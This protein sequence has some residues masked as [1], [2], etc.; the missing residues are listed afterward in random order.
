MDYI[1]KDWLK[2]IDKL[3]SSLEKDVEEVRAQK[4]EVQR[5]KAEILNDISAG[6]YIRDDRKIVIS[7][8][9]IIIG[10]VDMS[11][12]LWGDGTYSKVTIRA[13]EVETNGVGRAGNTAGGSITN[14]ASNIRNIAVDPGMDGLENVV[15]PSSQIVNQARSIIIQSNDDDGYFSQDLSSA[16]GTGVLIHADSGITVDATMSTVRHSESLKE[17]EKSLKDEQKNLKS[18]VSD[19]KSSVSALIS[20]IEKALDSTEGKNGS[21][22]DVFANLDDLADIQASYE[23]LTMALYNAMTT[24]LHGLSALAET[25]RALSAL[26]ETKKEIDSAKGDFKKNSTGSALTLNSET[27]TV[28][29][30]DGDGNVRESSAAGFYVNAKRVNLASMQADGTVLKDSEFVAASENITLSTASPKP[31]DGGPEFLAAGTMRLMSKDVSISAMDYEVKDKK[32]KEKA[33]AKDGSVL[34]RAE[35]VSVVA[36]TPDGKCDGSVNINAK[37]IG[38]KSMDLDKDSLE[39]KDLA[40]GSTMVLVSEKMYAG[41]LEKDKNKSKQFQIASDKIGVVAKTTAE[42]QQD[43]A[44]VQLDGGNLSAGG[45]KTNIFG[46]TTVNGKAEFKADVKAPKLTADNLEA[47]KSFKSTNISDG[48]A[49][50]GAPSSASLSQKIK[51]EAAPKSK[52]LKKK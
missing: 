11:G 23:S 49:V 24:Y 35:N 19:S 6:K 28:N 10:N 39:E 26:A 2:A 20:E 46:A 5:M 18:L 40:A 1:F 8:P 43:K 16:S 3:Q 7:A 38:I 13:N 48:I 21:M 34:L 31:K 33:L 45:S 44:T 27:I 29:S 14:K 25:N 32:V 17:K 12:D 52:S 41:A 50:P 42:I 15:R 30:I 51:E 47:S 4:E 37:S 22:A 9:E 36:T